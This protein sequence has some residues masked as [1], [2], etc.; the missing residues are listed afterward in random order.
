VQVALEMDPT[1]I[2]IE[3]FSPHNI[4]YLAKYLRVVWLIANTAKP[5]QPCFAVP[6]SAS[7]KMN[8]NSRAWIGTR[9]IPRYLI[10]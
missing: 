5:A 1:E 7:H 9:Y 4:R 8:L 6:Q 2:I 3:H 10:K